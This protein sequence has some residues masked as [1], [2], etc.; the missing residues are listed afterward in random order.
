LAKYSTRSFD[1]WIETLFELY[2]SKTLTQTQIALKSGLDKLIA[3]VATSKGDYTKKQRDQYIAMIQDAVK[4]GYEG[5]FETVQKEIGQV[6]KVVAGAYGLKKIPDKLMNNLISQ[7]NEIQGYKF[8][9]LFKLASDNHERQLRT[10]FAREVAMGESPSSI[11]K[12]LKEKNMS[13]SEGQIKTAVYTALSEARERV[14]EEAYF[15]LEKDFENVKYQYLA[16]LDGNTTQH[17]IERDGRIYPD[18]ESI[19]ADLNSHWNCRSVSMMIV[20]KDSIPDRRASI[21]GQTTNQKYPDWLASLDSEKQK[22]VLGKKYDAYQ[23]GDYK[24]KS[25]ADIKLTGT[26][27]SLDDIKKAI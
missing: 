7:N 10:L 13:L 27:L 1:L 15:E 25:L 3:D 24:V 22:I 11:A 4:G 26:K 23:R 14:R 12:M 8:K 19:S 16:T 5:S 18:L 9:E 17:C 2:D 21:F 6:A 20:D